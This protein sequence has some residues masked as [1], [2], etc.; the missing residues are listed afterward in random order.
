M[1]PK[2]DMHLPS[3]AMHLTSRLQQSSSSVSTGNHWGLSQ[4]SAAEQKNPQRSSGN[5]WLCTWTMKYFH[6]MDEATVHHFYVSQAANIYFSEENEWSLGQFRL[7]YYIDQF[8]TTIQH[9]SG[10]GTVI[11]EAIWRVQNASK[12]RPQASTTDTIWPYITN[13][14]WKTV[15]ETMLPLNSWQ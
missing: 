9:V 8:S 7:L 12:G 3:S 6:L 4:G 5:Y 14:I 15:F 13:P 11:A 10:F 2:L 1:R